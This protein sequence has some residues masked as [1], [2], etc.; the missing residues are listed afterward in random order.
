MDEQDRHEG[1]SDQFNNPFVGQDK[2]PTTQER[3]KYGACMT[4]SPHSLNVQGG[5]HTTNS[6][7]RCGFVNHKRD[8]GLEYPV[9]IQVLNQFQVM[10]RFDH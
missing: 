7:W 10:A 3:E 1:L 5:Q 6:R 8:K 9:D 2:A 4:G